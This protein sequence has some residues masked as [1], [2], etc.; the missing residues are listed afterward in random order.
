[1]L[2]LKFTVHRFFFRRATFTGHVFPPP[3]FSLSSGLV[4][5][6]VV[7]LPGTLYIY[8]ARCQI[9]PYYFGGTRIWKSLRKRSNNQQGHPEMVSSIKKT[10]CCVKKNSGLP[11]VL[12]EAVVHESL[13]ELPHVNLECPR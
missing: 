6:S 13:Q 5:S 9:F 4:P 8:L 2:D 11:S 3:A 7:W 12:E 10:D 1:M